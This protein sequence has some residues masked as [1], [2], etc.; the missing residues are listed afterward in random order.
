MR[1]NDAQL[2]KPLV[3]YVDTKTNIEALTGL[4]EGS[5][6]YATDTDEFGSY[7]G[8]TWTWGQSGGGIARS[9]STTDHHLAVW[10]GSDADSLEDGGAPAGG[11]D[12]YGNASVTDGHLAVFDTDGYHIKDGG[13]VP[14]SGAMNYICIQ[15]QKAQNTAGGT[16]TSGAWR[17]RDLNTEVADTGGN[18]GVASNQITLDAGTYRCLIFCPACYCEQHQARLQN[19]TDNTTLLLGTSA[20]AQAT[21]TRVVGSSSV[22][23]GRFTLAAQKVIEVQH[24]CNTTR[25]T[26]GFGEASNFT[27]EIYTTAEFWK[28]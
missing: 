22:I 11:G 17:T 9:G 6:A 16:F 19:V 14:A 2:G 4:A 7:D 24:C 1:L 26:D 12:V 25:N 20:R 18:A 3:L 10:N 13:A 15:D 5:V 27:T 28:E 8:S 23:M 21:L